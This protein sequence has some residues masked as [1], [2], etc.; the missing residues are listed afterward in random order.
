VSGDSFGFFELT[1]E[2][3][4]FYQLDISG[5]GIPSALLSASLTRA[6]LPVGEPNS[7]RRDDFLDPP[8]FLAHLNDQF[9]DPDDEGEHF[10]TVVY[11]TLNKANGDAMLALAGHP[12]PFLVRASGGID[13]LQ[14]DGLPIGMFPAVTYEGQRLTLGPGDRLILHSDG[15]TECRNPAG[16]AFGDARLRDIAGAAA[17][18]SMDDL[19]ATLEAELHAWRGSADLEDDVS[20]LVLERPAHP[21]GD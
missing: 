9:S 20:I 2:L 15:V 6:M 3:I 8:R 5:H 21:G 11:G 4:G 17:G 12:L 10:A 1:P 7:V 18:E 13:C 19:V 14:A 16:E